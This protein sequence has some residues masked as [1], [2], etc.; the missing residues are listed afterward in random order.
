M[1]NATKHGKPSRKASKGTGTLVT[2]RL[3]PAKIARID[4]YIE[5]MRGEAPAGSFKRSGVI[6]AALDQ[7]LGSEAA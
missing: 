2:L 3:D 5:T 6:R 4:T 7:F 1:P